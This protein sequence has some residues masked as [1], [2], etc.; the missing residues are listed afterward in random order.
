ML[1]RMLVLLFGLVAL[2][3]VGGG[4]VAWAAPAQQVRE[5]E[6]QGPNGACATP[7]NLGQLTGA[8]RV[9]GS[10]TPHPDLI[11]HPEGIDFFRLSATPGSQLIVAI[12][13]NTSGQGTLPDPLLGAFDAACNT[14]QSVD[15]AYG[16]L[17]PTMV[18]SVPS[19]GVLIFAVTAFAD[20]D[21]IGAGN[22]G[23]SYA[24]TLEPAMPIEAISGRLLDAATG[25]APAY[26][27]S[28]ELQRCM[29]DLCVTMGYTDLNQDRFSFAYSNEQPLFAGTYQAIVRS[30][31]YAP[32]TLGPFAVG[33]G[34]RYDLGVASLERLPLIGAVSGRLVHAQ[35]GQP[36]GQL[37]NSV[38]LVACQDGNCWDTRASMSTEADGSFRF[39]ANEQE[40]LL[41]VGEY[42]LLIEVDQFESYDLGPFMLTAGQELALGDLFIAPLPLQFFDRYGCETVPAA[43]GVCN[44]GLRVVNSQPYTMQL[45][46]WSI[47]EA[48]GMHHGVF[49]PAAAQEVNLAPGESRTFA[50]SFYIPE[51][52][53]AYT[54]FCANFYVANQ[55]PGFYLQ[56]WASSF[57]FCGF[58]DEAPV[59]ETPLMGVGTA[60]AVETEEPATEAPVTEAAVMEASATEAPVTEAA[61]MEASA[62]EAPVT[63]ALVT[64]EATDS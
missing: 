64:E 60:E 39:V 57:I 26:P 34:A 4:G 17:E 20:F 50:F 51:N 12:R 41:T 46:V 45:N 52:V 8:L 27:T 31:R 61:V 40:N 59:T 23:G 6:E 11:A 62:T 14:L 19:D 36:L 9:R 25:S 29:L 53:P 56:P 28:V 30:G 2:F 38:A 33:A 16:S 37:V 54:Q 43:G 42:R 10:I 7:Q 32:L 48:V 55:V 22:T 49:Q 5:V 13:G 24:L 18:I 58:K 3:A 21:F 63:E 35:T 47:M 15:D 1:R 44:Y